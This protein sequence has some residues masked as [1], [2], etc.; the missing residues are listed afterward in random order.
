VKDTRFVDMM[1]GIVIMLICAYW[2]I[3]ASRM[4]KVELGIGPGGYPMFASGGLFIMGLLL[5]IQN[6]IKG[7]PKPQGKIDRKGMLRML[8]FV[9][10]TFVYVWA[11]KYLGFLLLTP[12]YL[13]FALYFFMYRKKLI[14]AIISIGVTAVLFIVFR[15]IFFVALPDFR[16]F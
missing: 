6:I 16:L 11:M 14:A 1:T 12:P 10:V 8:F 13:F 5:T 4:M 2:F 15:I 7:L 9:A 3:E